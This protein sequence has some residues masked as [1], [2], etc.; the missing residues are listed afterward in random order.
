MGA[1]RC[2][3]S[4]HHSPRKYRS[5]SAAVE[6]YMSLVS[7]DAIR[8]SAASAA[9]R[10]SLAVIFLIRTLRHRIANTVMVA[11]Q[12]IQV[13][14]IVRVAITSGHS[15]AI[16]PSTVIVVVTVATME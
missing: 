12:A 6:E 2:S 7:I 3:W 14:P 15:H 10:A 13:A 1:D 4:T 8:S 9:R 5:A 11:N 16:E